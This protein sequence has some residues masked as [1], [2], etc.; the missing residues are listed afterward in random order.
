MFYLSNSVCWVSFSLVFST[1]PKKY[2]Q[3]GTVHDDLMLRNPQES[4]TYARLVLLLPL[5]GYKLDA[6]YGVKSW[7]YG[8]A[9]KI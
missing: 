9:P 4:L 5:T 6:I 2:M 8:V 3:S 1:V 7:T